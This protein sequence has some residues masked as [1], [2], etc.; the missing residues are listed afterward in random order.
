[1]EIGSRL[2]GSGCRKEE[3]GDVGLKVCAFV[4]R[5]LKRDIFIIVGFIL[6]LF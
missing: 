3:V 5:K 1:M 4:A 2:K 6:E